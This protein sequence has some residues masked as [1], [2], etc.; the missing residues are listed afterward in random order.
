[1]PTRARTAA[2][3]EDAP[4]LEP[5]F[6]VHA[7]LQGADPSAPVPVPI[8]A[9]VD[10]YLKPYLAARLNALVDEINAAEG[11]ERSFADASPAKLTREWEELKAQ[12]DE[13]RYTVTVRARIPGDFEAVHAAMTKAGVPF[14]KERMAL[15]QT[16]RLMIDPALSGEEMQKFG[17]RIG[18]AQYDKIVEAWSALEGD[19][20]VVTVPKS[21]RP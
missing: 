19:L 5:K 15:W 1:M 16:A 4:S 14:T 20:P 12:F 10:V 2:V 11:Q 8:T 18:S 6:D 13:S 21:L 17:E 3:P 9:T 7:W